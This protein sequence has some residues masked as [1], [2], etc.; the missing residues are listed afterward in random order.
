[1]VLGVGGLAV[2]AIMYQ[3]VKEA[4]RF[5]YIAPAIAKG[6]R[7]NSG[8]EE[9][10]YRH[11]SPASVQTN[12]FHARAIERHHYKMPYMTSRHYVRNRWDPEFQSFRYEDGTHAPDLTTLNAVEQAKLLDYIEGDVEGNAQKKQAYEAFYVKTRTQ[13][14]T[15]VMNEELAAWRENPALLRE[16]I[17]TANAELK[18]A[19]E[20]EDEEDFEEP[21]NLPKLPLSKQYR[22]EYWLTWWSSFELQLQLEFDYIIE[23]TRDQYQEEGINSYKGDR[24][25][26]Q[27][28]GGNLP[29]AEI[30]KLN[31]WMKLRNAGNPQP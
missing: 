11:P 20:W 1:M 12:E 5:T 16:R 25:L 24:Y 30:N 2:C 6:I 8:W 29:E 10:R 15:K 14:L 23:K 9:I 18:Q 17:R 28:G 27:A 13:P 26:W 4:W 3:G 7:G 19:D 21:K 22:M 31:S